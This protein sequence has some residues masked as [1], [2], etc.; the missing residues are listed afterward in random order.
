MKQIFLASTF[1]ELV[2][3]AAGIDEGEY[4]NPAA[5]ALV[6]TDGNAPAGTPGPDERLLLVSNNAI[7]MELSGSFIDAPAAQSLLSRFDRVI[8]LNETLA[9][10]HVHPSSWRPD[11]TDVP[12]VEAYLRSAWQLG[13]SDVELILES[14]QVNPAIALGRVFNRAAIRVH[15][16]GLM[17]YGPTRSHI[18]LTNGQRMSTLHFLPLVPGSEPRL[19]A[20]YGIVHRPL[21]LDA[22][23]AVVAEIGEHMEE[24]LTSA[25]GETAREGDWAL[26]VGQ[27]LSALGLISDEDETGLHVMMIREAEKRGLRTVVFKPHPAAPPSQLD[28]LFVAAEEAGISLQILDEP[29]LAEVIVDRFR[30]ALVLGGFSTALMTAREIYGVPAVAIG[31]NMLLE[32]ITPYQNSNRIP[33]TI[34]SELCDGQ[35]PDPSASPPPELARLISAVTYCMAPNLSHDLREE[36][37]EFLENVFAVGAEDR[38]R[39]YFK[40][41]RLSSLGLPGGNA[42]VFAPRRMLRQSGALAV[43][44]IVRKQKRFVKRVQSR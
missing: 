34:I 10:L 27:Y 31:T 12:V 3:L 18:P 15:A 29:L 38:F 13:D 6:G 43:K 8:D 17:T 32:A 9:P 19:L 42:Q 24:A 35:E 20:E 5:P 37:T 1:F 2:C 11:Q 16:D 22:F 36:A 40:R 26:I 14:P 44:A 23:R 21:S 41:R 39:R 4:D 28:P 33:L 25:L 30:P 7:V